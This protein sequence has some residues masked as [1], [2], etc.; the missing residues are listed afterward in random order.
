MPIMTSRLVL[1]LKEVADQTENVNQR[2]L[3]MMSFSTH[4]STR[5]LGLDLDAPADVDDR[6]IPL[7][8]RRRSA[9]LDLDVE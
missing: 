4:F 6:A 1:S 2:S 7:R 3:T 8:D 5:E 9:N